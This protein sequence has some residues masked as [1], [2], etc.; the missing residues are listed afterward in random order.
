VHADVPKKHG[1]NYGIVYFV[2]TCLGKKG[3]KQ[4]ILKINPQI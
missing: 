2:F 3:G 1:H 4:R